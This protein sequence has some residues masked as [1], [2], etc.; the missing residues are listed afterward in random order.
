MSEQNT[1]TNA[2]TKNAAQEVPSAALSTALPAEMKVYSVKG[3][4]DMSTLVSLGPPEALGGQVLSGQPELFGRIDFQ[5]GNLMGGLFMGTTGLIRVTFPFT[6]HATI[7][8]GEVALTDATGK[9]HVFKAGDSY[10]IRQGQVVLWDV[11]SAY[12]IKSFFNYTEK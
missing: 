10:I 6:E 9:T 8:V 12:V 5:Q 7:L 3:G 4:V 11:K 1:F 2:S